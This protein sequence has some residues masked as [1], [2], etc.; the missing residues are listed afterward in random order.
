MSDLRARLAQAQERIDNALSAGEISPEEYN[1][2]RARIEDRLYYLSNP[3]LVHTTSTGGPKGLRVTGYRRKEVDVKAMAHVLWSIALSE[4][5]KKHG[6]PELTPEERQYHQTLST[7]VDAKVRQKHA[8]SKPQPPVA[9]SDALPGPEVE[10]EN[11]QA[12]P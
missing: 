7:M 3:G 4:V 9:D 5:R 8:S 6:K 1:R 11:P 12:G 10:P 2:L